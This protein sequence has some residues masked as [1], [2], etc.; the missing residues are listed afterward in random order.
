MSR[1][2]YAFLIQANQK[3]AIDEAF[4]AYVRQRGLE[5]VKEGDILRCHGKLTA[6]DAMTFSWYLGRC[7][8]KYEWERPGY[9]ELKGIDLRDVVLSIGRAESLYQLIGGKRTVADLTR[10][11]F[12]DLRA[13]QLNMPSWKPLG[14]VLRFMIDYEVDFSD[15]SPRNTFRTPLEKLKLRAHTLNLLR[16]AGFY[17]VELLEQATPGALLDIRQFGEKSL[18][19]VETVLARHGKRLRA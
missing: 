9:D 3:Q 15:L 12:D 5:L 18:A 13:V 4:V 7:G 10:R 8:L 16:G 1:L 14:E 17:W 11:T 19:E 2:S 6:L